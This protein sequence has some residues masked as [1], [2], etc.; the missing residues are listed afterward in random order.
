MA[1]ATGTWEVNKE[2]LKLARGR[3]G[4]AAGAEIVRETMKAVA[5]NW[6]RRILKRHFE[7]SAPSKYPGAYTKR[8]KV[9]M[10]RKAKRGHQNPMVFSGDMKRAMLSARPK[11]ADAKAGSKSVRVKL[12]LPSPRAAN[13]WTGRRAVKSTGQR[14]NFAR[15]IGA[16][17]DADIKQLV[18]FAQKLFR[19]VLERKLREGERQMVRETFKG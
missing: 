15:E 16:F 4:T 10:L 6:H 5:Q 11:F 8:T 18:Q 7:A 3:T 12:Q 1:D 2:F 9:Y 17:N 19:R 14:H 13:L